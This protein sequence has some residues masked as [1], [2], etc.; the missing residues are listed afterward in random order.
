MGCSTMRRRYSGPRIASEPV[1]RAR[2]AVAGLLVLAPLAGCGDDPSPGEVVDR[3]E[4]DLDGTPALRIRYGSIDVE[5]DASSVG[6]LLAVPAGPAPPGGWPIVAYAHGTTGNADDC[7]PSDDPTLAGVGTALVALASAG[8]VAG[9]TDYEGIG[10]EGPHPYLNGRSAARALVDAVRAARS[11]VPDAGPRWA[12]LGYSQG[13]HAA[14]W[15]AEVA[16]AL[17]PELELVGAAALAPAADPGALV[18]V[19]LADTQALVVAGWLASDPDVDEDDVLTDIGKEAVEAA[20]ETCDVDITGPLLNDA[21]MAGLAAY[22]A[23][24]TAGSQPVTVPVL[25]TQGTDDALVSPDVT[26]A[27]V[28]RTCALGGT[29]ELREY[30]GA[31]HLTIVPESTPD[32]IAWL[33]DRF[34]GAPAASTC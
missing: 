4:I 26:R 25:V 14:L 16:A 7:A 33:A 8:F 15:A 2:L 30:D 20:E 13:G 17:A 18:A 9:A 12:V 32:A 19:G 1:R 23:E 10:P 34:A 27:A 28:A 24:N 6:G 3:E 5:G 22:A 29:V 11:A 31:D 21:G